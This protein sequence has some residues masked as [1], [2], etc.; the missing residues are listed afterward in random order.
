MG[1][2]TIF[3]PPGNVFGCDFC[4][5]ETYAQ[6]FSLLTALDFA[7]AAGVI[8]SWRVGG[9]GTI[10]LRVIE[11]GPEGGWIGRGTSAVATNLEGGPNATNLPIAVGDLIGVEFPGAGKGWVGTEPLANAER[12]GWKTLTDDGMER[13][14]TVER[15]ERFQLNAE[16]VLMPVVSS[17]SVASGS[18]T[19]GNAV[20][21]S[22]L[23]LDG[24]TSVTFGATPAASFSV[25]SSNQ[26]TA[27]APASA[28]STV[29]LR[30]SGP[31][32]SSEVA[33]ADKYTFAAPAATTATAATT[34]PTPKTLIQGGPVLV[35]ANPAVTRFSQSAS[36]W[37]R[38]HSLPHISSTGGSPLGTTFS[39]SLNEPAT[40]TF[41]FTQNVAGRRAHGSCVAPNR[42]NAQKKAEVQTHGSRRQLRRLRQGGPQQ[43]ALPGPAVECEDAQAGDLRGQHHRARRAWPEGRVGVAVVHRRFATGP[44]ETMDREPDP[45]QSGEPGPF[46]TTGEVEL[47]ALGDQRFGVVSAGGTQEVDG[48]QQA[49]DLAHELAG[50]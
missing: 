31:G 41:T 5:G 26:I 40:A 29:D 37:R 9:K 11:G 6:S 20:K 24:A 33:P 7:P 27:I 19:G 13:E 1:D 44:G 32:G 38:G 49:R 15:G 28:A 14:P 45:W 47:W 8:K 39:F 12:L 2:P 35:P 50:V 30:V 48:F 23:Y 34:N 18:T 36:R 42:S 21:I 3:S 22:G 16:V 17:L 10:E 46:L 43:A 25:D 4:E